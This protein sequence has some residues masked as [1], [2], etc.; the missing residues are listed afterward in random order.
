MTKR[1][2]D[3]GG[4]VVANSSGRP[5]DRDSDRGAPP[6]PDRIEADPGGTGLGLGASEDRPVSTGTEA[7]AQR[8]ATARPL[9]PEEGADDVGPGDQDA[10]QSGSTDPGRRR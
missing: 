2:E 7:E 6:A 3:L 5:G 10:S 8:F 9:L 4:Q 1:R